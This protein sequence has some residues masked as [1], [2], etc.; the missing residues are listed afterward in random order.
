MPE[1]SPG[2]DP[3]SVLEDRIAVP[4][5]DF[6]ENIDQLADSGAGPREILASLRGRHAESEVLTEVAYE[7]LLARLQSMSVIEQAKGILMA[8]SRCTP[9][10]AFAMLRAASQR[11][12]VKVRDLAQQIVARVSG[13]ERRSPRPRSLL[14]EASPDG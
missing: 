13:A 10:E 8:E 6:S 12:N 9:D 11:S 2:S 4:Q 1:T 14:D 7:H 3:S 5:L